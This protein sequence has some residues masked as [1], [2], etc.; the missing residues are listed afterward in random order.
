[1]AT[2]ALTAFL[3]SLGVFVLLAVL[4]RQ[5][6]QRGRRLVATRIR[7]F[8]DKLVEQVTSRL[9][10]SITHFVRYIVQLSWYYSIHSVLRAALRGMVAA[11]N[12]LENVFER[13]RERTKQLR[14]EKRQLT[15]LN[16]LRQMADHRV[17]TALTPKQQQK[18]LDKTLAGDN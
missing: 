7:N 16:H 11:Y 2:P 4:F 3:I 15:E 6:R 1:M 18:L 12:Y 8:L 13:N 14:A 17:D 10:K 9:T 5:E